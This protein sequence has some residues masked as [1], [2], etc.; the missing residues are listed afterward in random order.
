VAEQ[1]LGVAQLLPGVPVDRELEKE[2]VGFHGSLPLPIFCWTCGL[3]PIERDRTL[4][5]N[6]RR[7]VFNMRRR[8]LV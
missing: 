3:A 4:T 8:M 2:A 7:L 5:S 6:M 1:G